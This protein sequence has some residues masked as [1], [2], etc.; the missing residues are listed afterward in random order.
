M[1]SIR[2]IIDLNKDTAFNMAADQYLFNISAKNQTFY[3]RF[4]SWK[5][6]S[7]TLGYMQKASETLNF[8]KITTDKASWIRRPTGGRA[9]FH[10]G[11]L[12][13]SCIFPKSFNFMGDTVRE[14]YAAITKCLKQGLNN[15]GVIC[16]SHD[17]YDELLAVKRDVKLPCFLAPNRDEIMVNNRKL[18]GSAQKRGSD[19]VLQHGSIPISNAFANLPFYLNINDQDA[20]TQKALLTRKCI[21]LEEINSSITIASLIQHLIT[22]FAETLQRNYIIKNWTYEEQTAIINMAQSE[23]F[24]NEWLI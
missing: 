19:S 20:N 3:M 14:S 16:N 6:P 17:S 23:S 15:A 2:F 13:Y 21:C 8:S 4:Y 24:I 12:T 7:I 1:N 11:D 22:G 5:T 9:V 10:N 18:I